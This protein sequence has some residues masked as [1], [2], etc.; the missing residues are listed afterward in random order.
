[1]FM[2]T[3]IPNENQPAEFH[4]LIYIYKQSRDLGLHYFQYKINLGSAW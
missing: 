1:M 2:F 4:L 3:S